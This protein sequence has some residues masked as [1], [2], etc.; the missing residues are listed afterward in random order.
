MLDVEIAI[1]EMRN[2]KPAEIDEITIE[3]LKEGTYGMCEG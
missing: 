2:N 1:P 3:M